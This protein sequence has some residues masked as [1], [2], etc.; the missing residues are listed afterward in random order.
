MFMAVWAAPSAV[1]EGTTSS[2]IGSLPAAVT[3]TV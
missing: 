1:P 3:L 2:S